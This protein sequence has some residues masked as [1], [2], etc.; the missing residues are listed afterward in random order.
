YGDFDVEVPAHA[1]FSPDED[2]FLFLDQ[3]REGHLRPAG[4]FMGKY[5]IRRAPGETEKYAR[6]WNSSHNEAFDARFLPHP[7]LTDRVYLSDLEDRVEQ[8]LRVGWDGQPI[9]G[10]SIE[11]LRTVNAPERRFPHLD[12]VPTRSTP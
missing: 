10:A 8:R 11:Q 2:V 12:T 5:T 3:S 1:V 9:P 6:T 7:E 4:M